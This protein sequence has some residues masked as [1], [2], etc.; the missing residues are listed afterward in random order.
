M[1]LEDSQ[2]GTLWAIMSFVGL[3]FHSLLTA[4][5]F[6]IY[7]IYAA[8]LSFLSFS[9]ITLPRTVFSILHWSGFISVEINFQ[10]ILILIALLA[11]ISSWTYKLKVLNKYSFLPKTPQLTKTFKNQVAFRD[12]NPNLLL[13]S[14]QLFS[15]HDHFNN[16]LDEFLSAIRVF[17]FLEK[18]VFHELARHL[19]TRRLLAGDTLS[20]DEDKSFYIV[21]DGSVQVFAQTSDRG[22]PG[23][24]PSSPTYDGYNDRLA[25]DNEDD[26]GFQ[27][28]NVV[29]S[30]GTLSSLFTILSLLTEGVKLRYEED[31]DQADQAFSPGFADNLSKNTQPTASS[32]P[33]PPSKISLATLKRN[34]AARHSTNL[35]ESLQKDGRKFPD[36]HKNDSEDGGD[37]DDDEKS[38]KTSR[39]STYNASTATLLSP[40]F[41]A[42]SQSSLGKDAPQFHRAPGTSGQIPYGADPT[43]QRSRETYPKH[44]R[45]DIFENAQ[46]KEATVARATKDTTLAVIPSE[47]FRRLTSK[48]P[49]A[50]AH[51]V[52]VIL[53]R[54]QRVTFL[55]SHRYL[56]LTKELL[57]T[58]KAFN[59]IACYPLP[60][61]FYEDGGM[62]RL[63]H[64]FMPSSR[65]GDEPYSYA[66]G[67][68][69][70]DYTMNPGARSSLN[71]FLK[72]SAGKA[73]SQQPWS[74]L[75]VDVSRPTSQQGACS[76]ESNGENQNQS[77]RRSRHRYSI[78]DLSASF[79]LSLSGTNHLH[80]DLALRELV[81]KSIAKSIGLVQQPPSK[82]H[83]SNRGSAS[84]VY[85]SSPTPFS[86]ASRAGISSPEPSIQGS[87]G[88]KAPLR[89]GFCSGLGSLSYLKSLGDSSR[90]KRDE[91]LDTAS[92]VASSSAILDDEELKE[93]L[94]NEVQIMF[95]PQ[96]STLVKAGERNAGLYFVIDGFLDVFMPLEHDNKMG[97]NS[98]SALKK[99]NQPNS[100]RESKARK[101]S[102]DVDLS[103]LDNDSQRMS[104][105]KSN[106]SARN[107]SKSSATPKASAP[108]A[109]QKPEPKKEQTKLFTIKPG[110]IAGYLASISGFPSYV[111]IRAKTDVYVG[112]LSAKALERIM[113][114]RPI[115]LLTLAKRLISLLSPLVLH[116][117]TALEWMAV[118]AGQIIY[119]EGDS[120][121]NLYI[122]IG[123]RL[124]SISEQ[125]DGG[126]EILAEY[127]QGES[128]GELDCITNT[129]RKSTLHAIRDSELV[130]IPMTLFNA[131]SIRHPAITI[132]V[133]RL[134]ASRVRCEVDA[135]KSN[136]LKSRSH[137]P[138]Y[139]VSTNRTGAAGVDEPGKGSVRD[140][141]MSNFNLKTVAIIPNTKDVP[142]VEF[143]TRLKAALS[144]MNATTK[145]LDQSAILSVLGRHAFSR[146]GKLKLTGWLA[147]LEQKFRIVLYVADTAVNAPWTQTCI[148]Q[149][150]Y[151]MVVCDGGSQPEVGEYERL[152]SSMK[153]TARKELVLLHPDRNVPAGS[154]RPWLKNRPW[155]HAHHHV[156][157][158][159]A[160]PLR[161]NHLDEL[162]PLTALRQ[163]KRRVQTRLSKY[164]GYQMPS[165]FEIT[166]RGLANND[167]AR[168][169]RRLCGKSI[170]VV[171]GGGGARGISH[172]G[173]IKALQESSIP[174]DMIG[175][176]SIGS[177]IGGLYA[178][179]SDLI[180]T[181]GRAKTFSARIATYWRLLTDLTYPVVAYT[182]GHEFNRG[183][184]KSFYDYH[185][186]D[187]WLP[188][189]ANTTNITWSRMEVHTTGYAWRYIRASMSL[190]GLL[191]P[192]CDEGDMLVDGGYI[193]N[194]PVSVMLRMGADSVFAVDVGSIDD[195]SP[196]NFPESL[197]GWWLLIRRLNPWSSAY[198]IPTMTDIQS[199]LTYVSSVKTLEDAK[200]TPGVLYMRM[201]VTEFTTLGFGRF[202]E[203]L[204]KGY[205]AAKEMLKDLDSKG[206]LPT[207][208]DD[209]RSGDS[210][211][212]IP[213][214]KPYHPSKNGANGS[215]SE[216]NQRQR[217]NVR[218]NSV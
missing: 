124:R 217:L 21:V 170:A 125:T 63:R 146:L 41:V 90:E 69:S 123:G 95:F 181:L 49:N 36:W 204:Q 165:E 77:R 118:D 18:P 194:L 195:T 108:K 100:R 156:E 89:P 177:F 152:L 210:M 4:V 207:G 30:G 79:Q 5:L 64:R 182:T 111:D 14:K 78:L 72:Q 66:G 105:S 185:I 206:K 104:K 42:S 215:I 58:E 60:T 25:Y 120:S 2:S 53:A 147:E 22:H 52:Q 71:D 175:G 187:F 199:R 28:L 135:S 7:W 35:T 98:T 200:A 13:S 43:S 202:E 132:Q 75:H 88:G 84:H 161:N 102:D 133:S 127:G 186:E 198:Q 149:A 50:V 183:I 148:R 134:I 213:G 9:T 96:D 208:L 87:G 136:S 188:F 160:T 119:R 31:K 82:S 85:S 122:V 68:G 137:G 11:F 117:D 16:Y 130:R 196:R 129:S 86:S 38:V 83:D 23:Q 209:G 190:A 189:W 167:F 218:R 8:A 44:T 192:L 80:E 166:K 59:E 151:I 93:D 48:F 109:Q 157:M 55:T 154:T 54:L 173:V 172:I 99:E 179:N 112:F 212:G 65:L 81:M 193:D 121:D 150:D 73:E 174:I 142:I 140:L 19:Q 106:R 143:A 131:I 103:H 203:I 29:E 45:D 62:I 39:R 70:S 107:Q 114:R 47:A 197:S 158:A 163:L 201:P 171:L 126:V 46:P 67:H 61:T 51:I 164:R 37:P 141:G 110:G 74:D 6:V 17:G 97:N 144:Q 76:P 56:G 34:P 32:T 12:L 20:L 145:M 33:V 113:D 94:P 155:V 115:V 92:S 211:I 1:A 216:F 176:T 178:R 184:Y 128:I 180:S 139:A 159:G 24:N 26:N 3:I 27:L 116:I 10:K 101:V 138:D 168:L 205:E 169:A 214:H 191:P 40:N 153:I 15:D 57:R 162:L 91:F